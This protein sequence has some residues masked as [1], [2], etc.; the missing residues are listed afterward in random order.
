MSLVFDRNGKKSPTKGRAS[1]F[2]IWTTPW[3]GVK[4]NHLWFDKVAQILNEVA[5]GKLSLE[6]VGSSRPN[7]VHW[8]R[9][10]FHFSSKLEFG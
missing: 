1:L 5:S 6:V 10:M 3:I 2:I 8:S 4:K 9:T 7:I